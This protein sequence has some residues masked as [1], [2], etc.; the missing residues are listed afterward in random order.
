MPG[1][2]Q[3]KQAL[4]HGVDI[5]EEIFNAI[6]VIKRAKA[7][8]PFEPIMELIYFAEEILREELE[9][10]LFKGKIEEYHLRTVQ[11]FEEIDTVKVR[12]SIL[13]SREP[14]AIKKQFTETI[15]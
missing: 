10:L 9:S 14:T 12:I 1:R 13:L 2:D 6:A 11:D 15:R 4:K 7:N 3:L 5:P 8:N